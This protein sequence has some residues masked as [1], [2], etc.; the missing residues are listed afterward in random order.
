MINLGLFPKRYCTLLSTSTVLKIYLNFAIIFLSK[1][2]I[3]F[4]EPFL[5]NI[6]GP[7]TSDNVF[8]GKKYLN[9]PAYMHHI[10]RVIP[11]VNTL[12]KCKFLN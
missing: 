10:K 7:K 2:K 11:R 6:M 5:C 1:E 8:F 3:M 9:R 4:R 12:L